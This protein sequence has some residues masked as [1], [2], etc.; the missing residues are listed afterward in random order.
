[1]TVLL[2][3]TYKKVNSNDYIQL[4]ADAYIRAGYNVIFEEQNF[5][6]S[7]FVPDVLH[8]QWPEAIYRWKKIIS[9]N[10]TGLKQVQSRLQWYKNN[11]TKIVY[12]VHNLL[13]HENAIE[14]DIKIYSLMLEYSDIIAHHGQS[15]IDIIKKKYPITASKK[16]VV[17]PHGPYEK[18]ELPLKSISKNKYNLPQDK[19]IYTNF[20]LQRIYKGQEFCFDLFDKWSNNNDVCFFSVGKLVHSFKAL[21]ENKYSF[22]YKKLYKV[23]PT[24]E[25]V[26]I[27]S[28]TD[29]FFLGHSS[30]LNSGLIALALTYKKP[31]IFPDIGNFKDQVDGWELYETYEVNNIDSALLA[32]KRM[33]KRLNENIN[34][35]N[36]KWLSLNSWDIHI[37]NLS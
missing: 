3:G 14:F 26:D 4:V 12:T 21:E 31:I 33:H 17:A 7:N 32:L 24:N 20:G 23:I 29:V 19:L 10:D 28:A 27:I 15:S 25:V 34:I 13:P 11:N 30:G 6:F 36:E 2:L 16:H 18:K 22:N 8:I 5:M 1:M 35:C 9:M 37:K